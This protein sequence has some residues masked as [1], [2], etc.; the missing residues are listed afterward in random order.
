MNE[1]IHFQANDE[2]INNAYKRLVNHLKLEH[3]Y[4]EG[5]SFLSN[6]ENGTMYLLLKIIV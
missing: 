3:H 6:S 5:D 4:K 1:K 2:S